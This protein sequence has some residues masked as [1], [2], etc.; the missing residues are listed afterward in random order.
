MTKLYLIRHGETEWNVE[1]RMQGHADSPLSQLGSMQAYW[2]AEALDEVQFDVIHTSSSG[3]TLQTANI[4]KGRRE[5]QIQ[6]SDHWREMNLGEWEGRIAEA[7]KQEDQ[8]NFHAFWNEP[9]RYKPLAGESFED[10]QARVLPALNQLLAE[11]V[12]Q[13][14]ALISHTVT[15]KVIMAHFEQRPLEELWHP[16]YFHPTC[17]SLVEWR[18]GSPQIV[19]HAD[20]SHFQDEDAFGY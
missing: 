16:P 3:R 10:L 1:H 8:V 11:N 9:H 17:L 5:L 4:I 18:E 14:I 6:S 2:L 19:L 15:L 12:G 7:I 13:T 20:T